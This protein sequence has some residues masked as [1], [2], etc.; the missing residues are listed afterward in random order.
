MGEWD[1]IVSESEDEEIE[2]RNRNPATLKTPPPQTAQ[3]MGEKEPI[4]AQPNL[5]TRNQRNQDPDGSVPFTEKELR[6]RPFERHVVEAQV[7]RN[8]SPSS[9]SP[10]AEGAVTPDFEDIP[11]ALRLETRRSTTEEIGNSTSA[12]ELTGIKSLL[13]ANHR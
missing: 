8:P 4:V 12:L 1:D 10:A 5:S 6:Q 3:M 7:H 13:L 2:R 11:L 9:G